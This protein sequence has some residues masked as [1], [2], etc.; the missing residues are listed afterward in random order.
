MM[1]LRWLLLVVRHGHVKPDGSGRTGTTFFHH[2]EMGP[3]VKAIEDACCALL[4]FFQVL[5]KGGVYLTVSEATSAADSIRLFCGAYV[6]LAHAFY[7]K[8]VCLF[9]IEPSLHMC[10]HIEVRLRRIIANSAPAIL[11]PA[12]HLCEQSED[13]VGVTSRISRRVAAR[14][15]G[16][17]TLQRMMIR[18]AMEFK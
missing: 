17:R 14:T 6:S 7:A 2:P 5:H 13:F 9:H 15:C 10:K 8:Q 18:Y 1:L 16:Q 4:R 11:N 3:V 12:M